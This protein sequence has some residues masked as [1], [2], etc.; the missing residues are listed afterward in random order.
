MAILPSLFRI[1]TESELSLF[2]MPAPS[3]E[4]LLD[5]L[6]SYQR[7]GIQQIVSLLSSEEEKELNLTSEEDLCRICGLDFTRFSIDDRCVPV[8]PIAFR[9]LVCDTYTNLK[10]GKSIGIHCRAGIGRSGTLAACILIE[11][12]M[13]AEQAIDLVSSSRGT[14]IPDTTEQLSFICSYK[15]DS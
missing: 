3:S 14:R 8:D 6:A 13:E 5:E 1:K 4:W 7:E 9:R 15:S 12:G 2:V 10:L 11:M